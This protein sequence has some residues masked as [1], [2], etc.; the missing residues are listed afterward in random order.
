MST[1]YVYITLLNTA[2]ILPIIKYIIIFCFRGGALVNIGHLC[3]MKIRGI[4]VKM[5]AVAVFLSSLY[6][7][8]AASGAELKSLDVSVIEWPDETDK[9]TFELT[10]T[11]GESG[12]GHF[13]IE[14]KTDSGSFTEVENDLNVDEDSDPEGQL[15]VWTDYDIAYGHSYTY[16]VYYY[17]DDYDTSS[18]YT[19][20]TTASATSGELPDNFTAVSGEGQEIILEWSYPD[21]HEY[22]TVIERRLGSEGEW[23]HVATIPAGTNTYTDTVTSTKKQY[24]YRLRTRY[25]SHFFS[26]EYPDDDGISAYATLSTPGGLSAYAISATQICVAWN[27]VANEGSYIIERKASSETEFSIAGTVSANTTEFTDYGLE[28]GEEYT[29]R[30]KAI[31]GASASAYS[32]EFTVA[33][34]YLEAP[35]GLEALS[36]S[37]S[38]VELIWEDNSVGETGFEIWKKT[39]KDGEWIKYAYLYRNEI[40][41]I[42]TDVSQGSVY[43]YKVR[44]RI[45]DSNTYSAFSEEASAWAVLIAPPSGL[46]YTVRISADK[47]VIILKWTDNSNNESGFEVERKEEN[48]ISWSTV[49][50]LD[51]GDTSFTDSVDSDRGRYLY[52]VKAFDDTNINAASYSEEMLVVLGL[53][54]APSGLTTAAL[55]SSQIKLSWTDNS[56]NEDGFIIERAGHGGITYSEVGKVEAGVTTFIDNT[57][58]QGEYSYRVSSFN[59]SGSSG[60]ATADYARVGGKVTFSD[61]AGVAWAKSAIENL[62]SRNIFDISSD[63]KF[64]PYGN[65][66]RGELVS[67]LVR[68]FN[69]KA[70]AAGSFRDVSPKHRYYNEIMTAKRLGIVMGDNNGYFRPDRSVTREDMAVLLARTLSAAGKPLKYYDPAILD[71]FPDR[72]SITSYA[73]NSVASLRG[74]NLLHGKGG[75]SGE[76]PLMAPKDKA[77]RVEAGMLV[78]RVIDK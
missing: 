15:F 4:S 23:D 44:G 7:P 50:T 39:G 11:N 13:I 75:G 45:S 71:E 32:D 51:A 65:I 30:I 12:P 17:D 21:S 28:T 53:P 61:M 6:F 14:R 68:A 20:S 5:L 74:E 31:S 2:A 69:L 70:V 18:I 33:C 77:T 56:D 34:I 47:S 36:A 29:Y 64:H 9:G 40:K 27:D 22:V 52:R 19:N 78:Y 35:S 16:R 54:E 62:A 58:G 24:Y 73:L 59:K 8:Q 48:D 57:A 42:D 25:S 55:S 10:W 46:Q 1:F 67:I 63:G 60:A 38:S 3:K 72:D 49:S 41:Y 26:S 37:E 66:T 43:Y 76:M